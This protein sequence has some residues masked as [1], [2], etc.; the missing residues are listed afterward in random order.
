MRRAA[1]VDSNLK[2]IAAAFRQM[3]CSVHVEN[4]MVDLKVGYGGQTALVEVKRPG[5]VRYTPAQIK[6]RETWTGGIRLVQTLDDVESTVRTLRSW[7]A[8]IVAAS[9]KP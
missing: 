9:L 7:H 4:G 2:E 3:G 5:K 6:F 1:R 8:A